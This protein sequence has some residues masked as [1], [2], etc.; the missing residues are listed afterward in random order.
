MHEKRRVEMDDVIKVLGYVRFLK[1]TRYTIFVKRGPEIQVKVKGITL[2]C[3][4]RDV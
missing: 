4:P 1:E 2:G 3:T